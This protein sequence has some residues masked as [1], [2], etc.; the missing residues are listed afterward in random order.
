[1]K[2][3]GLTWVEFLCFRVNHRK[4]KKK[5]AQGKKPWKAADKLRKDIDIA[6][7]KHVALVQVFLTMSVSLTMRTTLTLFNALLP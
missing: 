3:F 5:E 2:G 6:E 7:Y 1:L 4:A